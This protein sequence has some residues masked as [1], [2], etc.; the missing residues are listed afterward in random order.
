[1]Q[2]KGPLLDRL[3]VYQVLPL[4][5]FPEKAGFLVLPSPSYSAEIMLNLADMCFS[6]TKMKN[7]E[8]WELQRTLNRLRQLTK[9][10]TP[11][12]AKCCGVGV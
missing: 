11:A 4:L 10:Q 1:M 8:Q 3:S 7:P 5:L 9:I 2:T 6:G 12:D